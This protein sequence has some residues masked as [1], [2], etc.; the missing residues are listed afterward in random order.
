MSQW[1]RLP[2]V[3]IQHTTGSGPLFDYGFNFVQF[4][5]LGRIEDSHDFGTTG[6]PHY[7]RED[8]EFALMATFSVHPPENRL[9]LILVV[10]ADRVSATR[11]ERLTNRYRSALASATEF[12]AGE[13]AP[14]DQVSNTPEMEK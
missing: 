9:A 12:A 6:D 8:T 3:D 11:A 14:D 2:L 13:R 7:S 4:H 5:R 10:D 1:R